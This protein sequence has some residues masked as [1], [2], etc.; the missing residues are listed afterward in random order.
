MGGPGVVFSRAAL[1]KL[2]SHIPY[3]LQHLESSH[4]DV[5]VG[6]CV[7]NVS[8]SSQ[9]L[10][11]NCFLKQSLNI[12]CSWSYEMQ[13]LFYHNFSGEIDPKNV[14]FPEIMRKAITLHPVKQVESIL[15]IYAKQLRFKH[16]QLRSSL[17]ART[18]QSDSLQNWDFIQRFHY[19]A[20]NFNPKSGLNVFMKSSLNL[21]YIEIMMEINK[22][23]R[24]KGRSITFKG[25][26]YGYFRMN[27]W[28]GIDYILDLF[29][30]Y[31]KHTGK[32][33]S[34]TVRKHIFASQSFSEHRIRRTITTTS[35]RTIVNIIL[36]LA[37]RLNTFRKFLS[38]FRTLFSADKYL[39][40]AVIMFPD[41]SE[42]QEAKSL[43]ID[44]M[45]DEYPVRL[46]QLAGNFSRASALQR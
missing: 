8:F 17:N 23:S 25:L 40:L 4:E 44:M 1:K 22:L 7:K 32:K 29:V 3:C 18:R 37:G 35:A 6:R 9:F 14:A 31:Q 5:E 30:S 27:H 38:N 11:N 41:S 20:S 39:S 34:S 26:N 28:R 24:A 43:L 46:A 33:F 45:R 42:T 19:S 36:P 16:L 13:H 21:N 2:V 10:I 15:E 12:S